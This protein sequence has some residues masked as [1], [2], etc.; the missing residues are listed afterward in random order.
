MQDTIL[1]IGATGMLGEPVARQLA[2]EG[3]CVRIV[4]RSPEKA[5]LKFKDGFE[6]VGGDVEDPATLATALRGCQGVHVNLHGGAT[7]DLERIG[8]LNTIQAAAQTGI[9]RITYLSGASAV[10][11]N[12]WFPDTRARYEAEM[13]IQS[14][15]IPYTIFKA[16]WFM[17]TLN[18]LVRGRWALVFGKGNIPWRWIAAADYARMVATAYKTPEAA[19][20]TLS[21]YGPQAYTTREALK[22]FTSIAHPEARLLSMPFWMA[23]IFARLGRRHELQAG[24]PFF[25]YCEQ[26]QIREAGDPAE[27]NALLG[28]PTITLEQWSQQH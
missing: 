25:R 21:I 13:A 27:A 5:R 28:A 22:I 4:S 19:N 1:V 12:C 2:A 3:H 7:P 10:K 23:H 15:G 9:S 8:T 14:S 11:E 6:V 20:K 17:E 16:T 24:L 18:K 26:I